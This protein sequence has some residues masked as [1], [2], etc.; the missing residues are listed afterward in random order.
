ME[1]KSGSEKNWQSTLDE[2]LTPYLNRTRLAASA[3]M[4]TTMP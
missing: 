3:A 1:K 4:P 2:A